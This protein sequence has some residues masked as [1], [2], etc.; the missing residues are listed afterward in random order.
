MTLGTAVTSGLLYDIR[1]QNT[2]TLQD[3]DYTRA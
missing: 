2:N 1:K 3:L